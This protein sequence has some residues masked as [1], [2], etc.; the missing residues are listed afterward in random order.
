MINKILIITIVQLIL[1]L[2]SC[3]GESRS[4]NSR[5]NKAV[6]VIE[7]EDRK[8]G[9]DFRWALIKYSDGTYGAKVNNEIV[10]QGCEEKIYC[11]GYSGSYLFKTQKGRDICVFDVRG[12]QLFCVTEVTYLTVESYMSNNKLRN[13]YILV[14]GFNKMQGVYSLRGKEIISPQ[15]VSISSIVSKIAENESA[16][17]GF[18]CE[19][20]RSDGYIESVY[21]WNGNFIFS[22]EY[23]FQQKS[24]GV[25]PIF[26]A[27]KNGITRLYNHEGKQILR[28]DDYIDYDVEVT[29]DGMT[30]IVLETEDDIDEYREYYEREW[31]DINGN[32]LKPVDGRKNNDLWNEN[33]R[34]VQSAKR[35]LRENMRLIK[36]Y[37]IISDNEGKPS[38]SIDDTY[39]PTYQYEQNALIEEVPIKNEDNLR[40]ERH[41]KEAYLRYENRVKDLINLLNTFQSTGNGG[42]TSYYAITETKSQ[43]R[44]NQSQMLRVRNEAQQ[45]GVFISSSPWESV[46]Y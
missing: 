2:S 26:V 37:N 4:N 19:K 35:E 28:V 10:L 22:G 16:I 8:Q 25:L 27:D 20:N 41:Y 31:I 5:Q 9:D 18:I 45:Y 17:W 24:K 39:I 6:S 21:D 33:L 15:F 42:A 12:N 34:L 7:R 29:N 46:S 32:T 44:D 40:W 23:L 13:G 30:Y 11:M 14:E 38:S 43:I 36:N 1:I 3:N